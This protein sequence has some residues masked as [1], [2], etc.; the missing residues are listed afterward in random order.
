MRHLSLTLSLIVLLLCQVGHAQQKPSAA[1]Q[2]KAATQKYGASPTYVLQ[3]KFRPGEVFRTQVT[4]LATVETKVKGVEETVKSRS[5]SAKAW[6][7]KNVD[8]QGNI[9]FEQSVEWV[10]MWKSQSGRPDS[11]F[12]SRTDKEVPPDYDIVAKSV[13]IPLATITIDPIGRVVKREDNQKIVSTS[14]G[15]LT[16]PFPA[17]PI[18]VGDKWH[19]PQE[20]RLT[21]DAGRPKIVQLRM[22]YTLEKVETSVATIQVVTQVLTPVDDPKLESQ[23]VQRMQNGTIRFDVEAGRILSRQMDLDETVLGFSGA[24][25]S[26]QYLARYSEEQV[27]SVASKPT[28]IKK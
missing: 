8:S 10:E 25:S 18:K 2:L 9:T 4:H 14:I 13:G 28:A 5:V 1:E 24:D 11:T 16:V 15:D 22:Q 20:A 12:D 7:I 3:Y 19:M 26:M 17:Q 23:L 21:D 27:K 6:K